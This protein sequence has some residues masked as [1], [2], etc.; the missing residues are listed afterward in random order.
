MATE[1]TRPDHRASGPKA[2]SGGRVEPSEKA[3][4]GPAAYVD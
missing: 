4:N 1:R 2:P 3:Y